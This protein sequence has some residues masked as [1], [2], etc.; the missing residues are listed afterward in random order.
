MVL[1]N[2]KSGDKMTYS[3]K[4]TAAAVLAFTLIFTTILIVIS[5]RNKKSEYEQ[6]TLREYKGTVALYKGEKIIDIYDGIVT[7]NLPLA[8]REELAKGIDVKNSDEAQIIIEDY[9]G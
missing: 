1:A 4:K 3:Y 6:Y 8:D 7:A 2:I 9:D 5:Y